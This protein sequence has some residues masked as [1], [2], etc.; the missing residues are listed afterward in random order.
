M[1][2]KSLRELTHNSRRF[3]SLD[4]NT[5]KQWVFRYTFLELEKDLGS[6]GDITTDNLFDGNRRVRGRIVTRDAGVLAGLEEILYFLKDGSKDFRPRVAGDF[7]I[8]TRFKDGD[9]LQEGDV[10]MEIEAGV[11]DL[12]A[13]ERVVLNFLSRMSGVATFSSSVVELVADYDVLITSTRKTL[14]GWLDK[15]AVTVGGGGTHRLNLADAIMIKDNHLALLGDFNDIFDKLASAD[16]DARFIEI[17]VE[18]IDSAVKVA[19]LF[20]E[21]RLGILGVI[22]LD[23]MQPA[24]IEEVVAELKRLGVHDDVLLEASGGISAEN[25]LEYAKTGVD[26]ISM[27]CLTGGVKGLDLSLE[28]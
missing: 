14:W 9:N 23:N 20:A 27:G 28:V 2:R 15:K 25:V 16:T 17:E 21:K 13:V 22:L 6:L 4:N 7:E 12:L 24:A 10:I 1:D 5:Y 18:S 8:L 26:I 19:E 3:L 11:K